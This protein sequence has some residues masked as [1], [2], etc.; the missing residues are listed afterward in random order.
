MKYII[1]L[2]VLRQMYIIEGVGEFPTKD[3]DV[4]DEE[5]VFKA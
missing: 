5:L 2:E 1:Y 3:F 4:K